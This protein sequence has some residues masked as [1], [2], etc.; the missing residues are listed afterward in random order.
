M[1]EKTLISIITPCYNS[2]KYIA[3]TIESVISQVY[4][5]WEMLI[6]DDCSTD[7]SLEIASFYAKK[8]SRIKI[9][10]NSKNQGA[11]YSRNFAIKKAQGEYI[12]FIDSDDLW[13]SD[14]LN[15]QLNFMKSHNADFS[16]T[17]YEYI[18][19]KSLSLHKKATVVKKL[20]YKKNLIHN[21]PGCLTVMYNQKTVGKIESTKKGN[22]DD[23]ALFLD[24]LKKC[25]NAMGIKQ[26][27]AKYRK[28]CSSISYNRFGMIKNHLYVLHNIEKNPKLK[29][30]LYLCTHTFILYFI[31]NR[32]Y[33]A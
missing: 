12:A 32:R 33:K 19:E 1:E 31:K 24:A 30:V 27:L 18:N 26:V 6:V 16:F 9:F 7:K 10:K 20:N 28:H 11:C 21:W 25:K 15:V 8:E 29:A 23:Y 17:E 3:E 2:E 14:K 22:G 13:N 5:N 4:K